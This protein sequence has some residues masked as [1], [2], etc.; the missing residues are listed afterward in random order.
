MSNRS[1][2]STATPVATGSAA[3][4]TASSAAPAQSG[5]QASV[6]SP[7]TVVTRKTTAAS[8]SQARRS[9]SGPAARR[10][11]TTMDAMPTMVSPS[12]RKS[13]PEVTAGAIVSSPGTPSGLPA[14]SSSLF[15]PGVTTTEAISTATAAV[16]ACAAHRQRG[17]GSRPSG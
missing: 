14:R 16:V 3:T 4:P 5:V 2:R 11:R 6:A 17:V 7:A 9:R 8:A 12:R 15:R 1:A 13:V 10:H